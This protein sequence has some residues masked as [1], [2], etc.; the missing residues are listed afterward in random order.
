MAAEAS[1]KAIAYF[2]T[3]GEPDT[4]SNI[5][6]DSTKDSDEEGEF[7]DGSSDESNEGKEGDDDGGDDDIGSN[8]RESD[9]SDDNGGPGSS[10]HEDSEDDDENESN[11]ADSDDTDEDSGSD[12]DDRISNGNDVVSDAGPEQPASYFG[13]GDPR[14]DLQPTRDDGVGLTP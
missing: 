7:T 11:T 4:H 1:D 8:D 3:K 10:G 14:L 9:N 13:T 6:S 12:A 5:D 2:T